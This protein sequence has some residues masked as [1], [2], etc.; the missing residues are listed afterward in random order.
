MP[1][2]RSRGR[3]K[4]R[5]GE[6]VS[7][8]PE[9]RRGQWVVPGLGPQAAEYLC[10]EFCGCFRQV[11]CLLIGQDPLPYEAELPRSERPS[12]TAGCK[13]WA[14]KS[15]AARIC[16]GLSDA[17]STPHSDHQLEFTSL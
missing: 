7:E 8:L 14:A 1:G 12:A 15:L 10:G 16:A 5:G 4:G 11:Y 6:Q 9:H 13:C 3:G 2:R 17:T